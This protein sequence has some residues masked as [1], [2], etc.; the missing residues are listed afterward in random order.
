[1]STMIEKIKRNFLPEDFT[2]TTWETLQPYFENLKER[3][4]DSPEALHQ[5]MKDVSEMEAVIS[6]DA[7][8]RQIKMTCDTTD[9]KLEEAFTYFCLEIEPKMKPYSFELNKKLVACPFT[10]E[11]DEA[12]YYPYLR[13]VRNAMPNA[14]DR[15]TARGSDCLRGAPRSFRTNRK[16]RPGIRARQPRRWRGRSSR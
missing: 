10:K 14:R 5:W 1:M 2:I 4:L 11:L 12:V 8:W 16:G 6:E 9:P 3:N 7:C 13:S 15:M